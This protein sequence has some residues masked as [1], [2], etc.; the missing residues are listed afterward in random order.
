MY[1]QLVNLLADHSEGLSAAGISSSY[2]GVTLSDYATVLAHL[3]DGVK[4]AAI[5]D[6]LTVL[7]GV[8][9]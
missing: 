1:S 6:N 4:Y 2:V 9:M 5:S 3:T 8:H 7:N